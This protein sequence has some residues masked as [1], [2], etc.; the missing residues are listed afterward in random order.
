ME[1]L[2]ILSEN[3]ITEHEV[4]ALLISTC[5]DPNWLIAALINCRQSASQLTSVLHAAAMPPLLV[6]SFTVRES[7]ISSRAASITLA[8]CPAND[9]AHAFPMPEE[10]PVITTTLSFSDCCFKL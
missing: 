5:T 3:K 6:I 8:P 4:L 2:V 1:R 10:A 9:I 7:F